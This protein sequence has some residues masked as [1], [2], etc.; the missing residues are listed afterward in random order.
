MVRYFVDKTT[1]TPADT[2]LAFGFASLL[3]R[4][5]PDDVGDPN[6]RIEDVG[7]SYCV[8][9]KYPV[10][11]EWFR[12]AK[13]F[14]LL[15]GLDT[16]KKRTALPDAVDYADQQQRNSAYFE[17]RKKGLP[18]AD[19]AEQG[20]TPPHVDWPGWAITNQMS[21]TNAYNA[22]VAA[23]HGHQPGFAD[24]LLLILNLFGKRPNEISA[25]EEAWKELAKRWQ[26]D[27]KAQSPQLQVVNPGTGKGGNKSKASGLSIG[28]LNGFWAIEYLKFVGLFHAA[29]PRIVSGSK[30]RK[31]YVLRPK[32]LAWRT[33]SKVFP[34]F[35]KALFAQTAVKMDVLATLRYCRVFLE[36]WKAGQASGMFRF[37]RGQPGDHIAALEAI[38]YKH[39]GSAHATMNL[40]SLVLPEWLPIVETV[41][42]ANQFLAMLAEHEAIIRNLKEERSQEYELLKRYRNFLSAR[43]LRAFFGFT[44]AYAGYVMGKFLDG[45]FPPR[46]FQVTSLEVLIMSHDAAL[47]SIVH[48]EGF[49]RIAEA[50]RHSTVIP[51]YHKSK[52]NPGP[53]EIRYGLGADLLRN[54]SYPEKFVQAISKFMF[55]YNQEN[56]RVNERFK[57]SPPVRRRNIRAGDIEQVLGLIDKNGDSDTVA[58]LLVAF[59]YARDPRN[60]DEPTPPEQTT[61]ER[62]EEI[63]LKIEADDNESDEDA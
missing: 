39:L 42:Q 44:A 43:D 19:L 6:L 13:P 11:P 28:G 56:E 9:I 36:Q 24:L 30:D 1:G 54:A 48:N 51:Q 16:A 12:D 34:E 37:G 41:E 10:Q 14:P 27:T 25:T 50:I 62:D 57:G 47:S 46:Q 58:N 26:L 61:H 63:E 31:T 23:W 29:V 5:I 18:E 32:A 60:R 8:S 40:S 17:A 3:D 20:L 49:R 59:G 21:A 53:F 22:L 33:H 55:E 45:G 35:Q 4:L 15:R 52:G 2:L 7:D 38:H